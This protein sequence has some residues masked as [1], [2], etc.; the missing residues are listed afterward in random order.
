MHSFDPDIAQR[1]GVNA[2]VLYHNIVWWCAQNA[3][4]GHNEHDGRYWTYNSV[5]AWSELFPYMTAK[6]IR[7]SLERLEAD[8]MILSG[9]Y[10]KSAYDRTK[11]FCPASQA[12][13]PTKAN[14]IARDGEPIPYV[15]TDIKPD[16]VFGAK[17]PK[18]PKQ[19][20]PE[21]DLPEEW[22]PNDKNVQDAIDRGFSDME[23][24]HEADRFGNFHRSKQNR[25]R[26]WDAAWRT[27]LANARKYRGTQRGE[28]R[29]GS[30]MAAAFA[31]VAAE[32]A[33]RERNSAQNTAD[34]DDTMLWGV[35]LS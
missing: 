5:R 15:N 35:D 34:P 31:T 22:V 13:L 29:K 10:N 26:D 6:Q 24:E 27:W 18:A 17:A 2:A 30:G 14:E 20:K 11:W 8:G 16:E 32:C 9:S 12:H 21:T 28:N 1:V 4:N 7:T 3:A 25:F 19:R 33:A 23:I